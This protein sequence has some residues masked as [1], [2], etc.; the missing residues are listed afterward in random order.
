MVDFLTAASSVV[1]KVYRIGLMLEFLYRELSVS[2]TQFF[3][4]S[5]TKL[6]LKMEEYIKLTVAQA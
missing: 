1:L 6:S 3:E 4:N 2:C 5:N